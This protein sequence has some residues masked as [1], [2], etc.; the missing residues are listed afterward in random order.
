[1]AAADTEGNYLLTL[2]TPE[3]HRDPQQDPLAS[4][5]NPYMR[6]R[7]G[8]IPAP[9]L[10]VTE[11]HCTHLSSPALALPSHQVLNHCFKP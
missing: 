4:T 10:L 5:T 7:K 1:M 11:V 6:A 8:Q 9:P 2:K 3:G